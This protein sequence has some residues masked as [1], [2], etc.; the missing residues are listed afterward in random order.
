M[1]EVPYQNREIDEMFKDIKE[2]LDRI[3]IQTTA[4][5]GKVRKIIIG[6]VLLAGITIGSGLA[7]PSSLFSVAKLIGI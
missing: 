6:M 4:T 7:N 5:N 2:K 1:T 3:E